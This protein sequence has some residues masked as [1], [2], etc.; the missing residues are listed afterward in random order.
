VFDYAASFGAAARELAGWMGEG[1][2]VSREDIVD[3][4]VSAFPETLL[5]L[6]AGENVGKLVLRVETD[7]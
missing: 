4:G 3:G 5:K 2:L 7:R 6:F 1:R